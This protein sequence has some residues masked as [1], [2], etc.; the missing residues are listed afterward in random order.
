MSAALRRRG[1]DGAGVWVDPSVGIALAHRRLA[2][3]EL[4]DLGA[5]PMESRCGRFVITFN[6]EIYNFAA[7]R[8]ELA[9]RG[10]RFRGGSDTEVLLAA[11]SEWGLEGALPHMVGMFALALWDR[12][13]RKLSLARDRTGEKPLYYGR[14]G[15]AFVF[16]SELSALEVLPEGPGEIDR[17][18]LGLYLRFGNVPAPHSIYS[19]IRKLPPACI[20]SVNE[21]G[22]VTEA[23]PYWSYRWSGPAETHSIPEA[24]AAD[25]LEKLLNEAVQLQSAADVP[26]G[27][28]L[29]GGIDSTTV[30]ALMRRH[31]RRVQTF[32]IGFEES[33]FDES[34]YA[35]AVAH[36]LCTDHNELLVTARDAM[37]V[38]PKLPAL[39]GEPFADSSQ[40][41]TYLV[42]EMARRQVTVAL[43]GDGA[44]ELFGGYSRYFWARSL[45]RMMRRLPRS[46]RGALTR[47][48]KAIPVSAVDH[49][50]AALRPL[51]PANGRVPHA[52]QKLRRV[53]DLISAETP[54]DLYLQLLSSWPDPHEV[55]D[56]EWETGIGFEQP[57]PDDIPGFTR[58]MM[59]FDQ[60]AYL[61][62]D[63]LVK[64]D[65][66]SMGVGLETRAPFLDHRIVEFAGALP[67]DL[68]IRNGQGKWLLREVLRR[69]VPPALVDRPKA[70]F[71]VPLDGWIRGP[72]REWA[73]ALLSE[74]KLR[75]HG[76][77]RVAPIRRK[78]SEHLSGAWNHIAPLW[79]VLAFQ[80]WYE[81]RPYS[82]APEHPIELRTAVA[83]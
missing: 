73:E 64:L 78:W 56:G 79:T 29:S 24:Q 81:H 60:A 39:Y 77:F 47:S 28:L 20:V 62:N 74:R 23:V 17:N 52:G 53:A 10:F 70:G 32:T 76:I 33:R 6:G 14:V 57:A 1:P 59:A 49:S 67:L 8:K 44:D 16:G 54:A 26:V 37:G 71:A 3:V 50:A 19:R 36:Y 21:A 46:G 40:I 9:G 82:R 61:P 51:L 41:P 22:D 7:L 38:I 48:L 75:E 43:T 45:W 25:E 68:K 35:R 4:S 66:A 34:E 12:V 63:I 31:T 13:D 2:V 11:V 18:A 5:Q 27:A 55:L 58:W 65:R 30:V 69:H 42:S 72:L 83:L 80:A 15:S